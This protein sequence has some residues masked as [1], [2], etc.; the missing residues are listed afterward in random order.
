MGWGVTILLNMRYDL[1]IHDCRRCGRSGKFEVS[2]YI[3]YEEW[4]YEDCDQMH[5][6]LINLHPGVSAPVQG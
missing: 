2:F 6:E 1:H 5:R 3:D 4:Y